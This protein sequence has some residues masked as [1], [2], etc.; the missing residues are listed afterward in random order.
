MS[1]GLAFLKKK[2]KQLQ[3]NTIM[4]KN[5]TKICGSLMFLIIMMFPLI[6]KGQ[7]TFQKVYGTSVD[8]SGRDVLPT[9][10]G[11]YL[12]VGVT[13]PVIGDSDI[14][15]MKT[16]VGGDT[17]WTKTFGGN[18]SDYPHTLLP[19]NDGNYFI[20]GFTKSFGAGG[21]DIWLLKMNPSGTIL[22]TKTYG[23]TGDDQGKDIIPT[24]DGNYMITGNTNYSGGLNYD[25]LLLKIDSSGAI[26]WTRNYG[27][28]HFESSHSVKQCL[29]GG[30]IFAGQ[31][32][33]YGKG[34]GDV[35]V[36]KT[37][38]IGD[39]LWTKTYGDTAADEASCILVNSDGT[40]VL[41]GE[42]SSYGAGNIDVYFLKIGSTGN[43]IWNKT[44][45]GTGKDLSHM[46]QHTADGGYV[47][48]AISRSFGWINPDMWI[49]KT[50]ANG[51]SLW[52]KHYGSWYHDHCYVAKQ[53]ADGGYIA[54]GHQEDITGR[55]HVFFVKLNDTGNIT[56]S[57]VTEFSFDNSII[58]YPNPS[59]GIFK[60]DF[61]DNIPVDAEIEIHNLLGQTIYSDKINQ[62]NKN[63]IIDI[64]EIESGIYF[65]SVIS[66]SHKSTKKI[67]LKK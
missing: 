34:A 36:V 19:T 8:Q 50:D 11:G 21:Y 27:G 67:I 24:S 52:T 31:T 10:D 17:L 64:S 13:T 4:I 47:I 30:Y 63:R 2:T 6:M 33:S 41:V 39:T 46:I 23:G 25:A 7:G 66:D 58:V 42:T 35:W 32:L 54:L 12:I 9:A 51:N 29:D 40:Y 62:S 65:F 53:T 43:M 57:A 55:L 5:D 14:Y 28:T 18:K 45:G 22:W 16:N 15:V 49:I 44:Y 26:L 59:N 3:K 56:P 20:L 38:S 48:G 61:Q 60:I 1:A 37:N